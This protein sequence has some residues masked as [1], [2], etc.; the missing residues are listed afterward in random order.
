MVFGDVRSGAKLPSPAGKKTVIG[1]E[2]TLSLAKS[3]EYPNFTNEHKIT[4]LE[5]VG[6]RYPDFSGFMRYETTF[7]IKTGK[8]AVLVLEDAYEGVEVWVNGQNAGIQIAPPYRFDISGLVRDGVNRLR[9]EVAN[10]LDR[11]VR[12][13]PVEG[14]HAKGTGIIE[15][16]GLIGEVSVW[17]K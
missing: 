6:L 7:E 16:S 12:T 11:E 13:M 10:T 4:K 8:T 5:N 14:V 17:V 9:I 1:R 3:K 2:W 15:P